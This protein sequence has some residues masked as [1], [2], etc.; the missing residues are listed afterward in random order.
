MGLHRDGGSQSLPP[1]EV[2][3]RRRLWWQIILFDSRVAEWSGAGT[4]NLSNRWSTRLPLNINDGDLRPDMREPPIEHSGATEMIFYLTKC[5]IAEFLRK[6]RSTPGF[7]CNWYELST[8]VVSTP[9]KDQAIDDLEALLS[10]KYLCFC[11]PEIPI[12]ALTR[13]TTVSALRKMRLIV[14]HPR[15]LSDGGASMPSSEKDLLITSALSQLSCYNEA[16]RSRATQRFRW[17]LNVN[18]PLEAFIYLLSDLRVRPI[19]ELADQAWR[20][21]GVYVDTRQEQMKPIMNHKNAVYFA[22]ANLQVKA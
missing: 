21:I 4:S 1:F 12:Q 11:E 20:Q 5:E 3:I 17:H 22:V 7:D 18:A 16:Y 13:A 2:E 14:H 15:L 8:P 10:R 19:G 6:T 9:A